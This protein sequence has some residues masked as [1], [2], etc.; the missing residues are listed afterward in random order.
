M[1]VECQVLLVT[2]VKEI[3]LKKMFEEEIGDPNTKK[4]YSLV[5]HFHF[6][7]S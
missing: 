1:D 4:T 3:E 2:V 7:T 6:C 5:M